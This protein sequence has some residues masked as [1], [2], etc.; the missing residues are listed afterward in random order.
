MNDELVCINGVLVRS[1]EAKISVFDEGLTRGYA[2]FETMRAY[3]GKIFELEAHLNRLENGARKV[4]L[5]IPLRS[6]LKQFISTT[7]EAN[8]LENA[9]V[10]LLV[11]RGV[12]GKN[13]S[14][15]IVYASPVGIDEKIYSQG[16]SCA[17]MKRVLPNPGIKTTNY[18]FNF[19]ALSEAKEKGFDDVIF[20]DEKKRVCEGATANIFV[21]KDGVL[22]TPPISAG[23]LSGI[24][25]EN[26]I[27]LAKRIG[28]KCVVKNFSSKE[29]LEAEE[30]FFASSVREITPIVRIGEKTIGSGKPGKTMKK[31]L[32]EYRKLARA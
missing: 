20:I 4:K 30:V 23:I 9:R 11:T 19:L 27:Q 5:E 1:S 28:L 21:L 13:A 12:E 14:T 26:V 2:L 16:I 3:N 7:L 15:V 25:R 6:Q 31:I 10:K 24:T 8:N 32:E 29:L 18:L 22:S 17:V